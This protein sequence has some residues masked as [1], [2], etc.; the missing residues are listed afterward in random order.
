MAVADMLANTVAQKPD[1]DAVIATDGRVTFT[2]LDQGA[3]R[4]AAQL[5][6]A[7]IGRGDKVAMLLGNDQACRFTATYFG[8][9]KLG[10][11]PV[12]LNI[13]WALPEKY[14]VLEHS[15]A[16]AIVAGAEHANALAG[17]SQGE[18][19]EVQGRPANIKVKTF[20]V[21][22]NEPIGG[23]RPLGSLFQKGYFAE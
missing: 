12:P 19:V 20:L 2:E 17:L 18:R 1:K 22:G 7:G 8:I 14:Y 9:H 23:F 13:R 3:A 21:H 15:D 6:R 11:V 4:I 16:A 10:A 5:H